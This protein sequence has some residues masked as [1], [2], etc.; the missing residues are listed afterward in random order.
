MLL[1]SRVSWSFRGQLAQFFRQFVYSELLEVDY[2]SFVL[3]EPRC[4]LLATDAAAFLD[5]A[6]SLDEKSERLTVVAALLEC[7]QSFFQFVV[8]ELVVGDVER[9]GVGERGGVEASEPN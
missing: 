3:R 8:V 1:R 2:L 6:K 9:R 4:Q 5:L 7:L